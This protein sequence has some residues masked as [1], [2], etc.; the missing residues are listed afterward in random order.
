[1]KLLNSVPGSN[2]AL[3]FTMPKGQFGTIMI[4]YTGTAAAGVTVT[5]AQLGNIQLTW[6]GQDVINCDAEILNLLDN[7]YGGVSEFTSAIGGAFAMSVIIPCAQWYDASNVYDI[8]QND[9]VTFN[10]TFPSLIGVAVAVTSQVAIYAKEKVGV[11]NY[12]NNIIQRFVVAS[13]ATTIADVLPVANV[14]QVYFKDP[15]TSLVTQIQ[16]Q[17]DGKTVVDAPT[18]VVSSY[19]AWIHQLETAGTTFAVEFVESKNYQEAIGGQVSYKFVFSG[20]ATLSQYVNY[21]TF[22][23]EKA[24]QSRQ[25]AALSLTQNINSAS[26]K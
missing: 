13:G 10:L 3:P 12:L 7:L 22:T 9:T 25:N 8:G 19:N 16:L 17:K 18:E 11:M 1:M 21:I 20:A 4:R 5:R 26:K 14:S 15:A 24:F 2:G 6:N 23:P